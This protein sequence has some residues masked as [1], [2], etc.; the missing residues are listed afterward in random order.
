MSN[1]WIPVKNGHSQS[2]E[3]TLT[4]CHDKKFTFSSKMQFEYNLEKCISVAYLFDR[5][6]PYKIGF[7]FYDHADNPE[8]RMISGKGTSRNSTNN[9]ASAG[10]LFSNN[11]ILQKI[12]AKKNRGDRV[13]FVHR[14]TDDPDIFF[15]KLRPE[16]EKFVNAEDISIIS[17]NYK[18]I[19]RYKNSGNK[20]IY[21]GKGLIKNRLQSTERKTWGIHKI[22]YSILNSEDDSYKWESFYLDEYQNQFGMLPPFNR[23]SG[24]SQTNE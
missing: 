14:D 6:D 20:V 18:G 22:E 10:T 5:K 8:A 24:H 19:Y 15:I 13:F 3:P 2:R 7:K 4:V 21:I 11:P 9:T 12:A 16:F 1:N 23:I 17:K